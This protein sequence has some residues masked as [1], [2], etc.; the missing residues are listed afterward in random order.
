MKKKLGMMTILVMFF[1]CF[2]MVS[3]AAQGYH[4]KLEYDGNVVENEAKSGYFSLIGT[5]ATPYTNVRV[6]VKVTGPATPKILAQGTDGKEFDVVQIGYFGPSAGFA[7]GGDFT[8]KTP[9][10]AIYPKA[11]KYISTIRLIDVKN[12][13]AVIHSESMEINVVSKAANVVPGTPTEEETVTELPKTGI[14]IVNILWGVVP[15][16]LLVVL[17]ILWYQKKHSTQE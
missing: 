3:H 12:G 5:G 13:N 7:V 16:I 2:L 1:S 6:E 14:D 17:G 9:I 10:R 4:F 8:N 15:A 11:G